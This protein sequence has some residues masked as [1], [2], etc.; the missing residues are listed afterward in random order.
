MFSQDF[1]EFVQLL[2]KHNA[3][4]NTYTQI[5]LQLVFSVMGRQNLIQISWKDESNESFY[6]N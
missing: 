2:T 4:A 3:M 6:R 5:Y 1:K